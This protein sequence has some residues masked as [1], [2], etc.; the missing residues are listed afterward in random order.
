MRLTTISM[1]AGIAALSA[2][3]PAG[4]TLTGIEVVAEPHDPGLVA[5][6]VYA[7]F[8]DP[9]DQLLA[10]LGTPASPLGVTVTGGTLF[11]HPLG[12]DLEPIQ[13]LVAVFPDL[14]WDT[15]VT[16]GVGPDGGDNTLLMPPWPGFGPSAVNATDSGWFITP[17]DPQGTPDENGRVLLGVF[18]HDG[19]AIEGHVLVQFVTGGVHM[20]ASVGFCNG[21]AASCVAGDLD[22]D[23]LV[24]IDD[25]LALLADWGACAGCP[26]DLDGDGQTGINDFLMLLANWTTFSV[27]PTGAAITDLNGDGITG[28]T[29]LV[30]LLQ[31]VGPAAGGCAIA[32]IDADGSVGV[33]DLQLMLANWGAVSN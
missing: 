15:F 12:S 27:I 16:I 31:C 10:V 11:Q 23:N 25:F 20:Q 2:G 9:D 18:T 17:D 8:S 7:R 26:A 29:D 33:T 19:T 4:A 22:G 3:G 30:T 28:F 1:A 6:T 14:A 5:C 21:P 13:A 24:T 32:D